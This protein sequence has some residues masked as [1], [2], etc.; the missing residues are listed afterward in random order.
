MTKEQAAQEIKSRYAEYLRPA[1]KR[2]TYICPLCNNG[3]G[4]DG[5]GISV[6][7]H[8]DGTRLKCFKCGFYGDLVD[9]YQKEHGGSTGEAFRALYSLFGVEIDG[10]APQRPAETRREAAGH[11]D[12]PQPERGAEATG[13]GAEPQHDYTAY[14]R[15]CMARLSMPEA[16]AY[17]A[18]RGISTETAARHEV[19][20][21]PG[22]RSPTATERAKLEGRTLPPTSPRLIVPTSS[23]SYLARDTRKE[24]PD[25]TRKYAKMKEGAVQLFNRTAL[26]NEAGRAVFVTEGEIDALSIIEAGAEAMALGSTSNTDKLLEKLREKPTRSTLILCLDND[27]S[28]KDENGREIGKAGQK[29]TLELA[30]GL[31]ALNISYV[32]ANIC[33]NH[34]DPNEALQAARGDFLE[35]VA[36]A[37]HSTAAKPDA[38]NDYINRLMVEDIK[39]LQRWTGRKTGF[40]NLDAELNGVYPGLYVVGA[41]SSL[42]KTTFIHQMADQMAAAGE[43]ILFFSLEQSRLEMVSKSLARMTAQR[44]INSASTSLAIRSGAAFQTRPGNEM[45]QRAALEAARAYTEAVGDRLSVIEGNFNCTVSFIGDYA[46]RYMKNNPG[47]KPLVIVDY[48]QIIQGDPAQRQSTKEQVDGNVTELKRLSRNLDIPVFLISSL[49]R[50]NYAQPVDFESFKESGGIE[51]SADVLFGLQLAIM[52]DDIFNQEKKIKEK[53]EKVREAKAET[54]RK[55]ELVCLKN[56]Y[57]RSSFEKPVT[58]EYYP[59]FDLFIPAKQ[60]QPE[61]PRRRL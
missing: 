50:Q 35:A 8:S 14:F 53:R 12:P 42:G 18:F 39:T 25:R 6:D 29:A 51:Y 11:I 3:S 47:T 30:A 55:I 56:R 26:W 17:L 4:S 27:P 19:G 43:H 41:I 33:G 49:N 58:F 52:N 44:D 48:L 54:P 7:P 1:K 22:W 60:E 46:R 5:D 24:I 9:L 13:A 20:F 16:Q 28:K 23:S 40:D 34:K 61:P 38:V 21:D 10:E 31:D 57:G 37:E 15:E 2:G 32:I 45:R 59:Q 36:A